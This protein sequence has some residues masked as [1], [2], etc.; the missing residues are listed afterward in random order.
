MAK[1]KR[2]NLKGWQQKDKCKM[3]KEKGLKWK[4]KIEGFKWNDEVKGQKWKAISDRLTIYCWSERLKATC[5]NL[6]AWHERLNV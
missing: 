1:H 4:S 3:L 6:K 2:L 5:S